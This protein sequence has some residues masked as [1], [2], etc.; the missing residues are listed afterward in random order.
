MINIFKDLAAFFVPINLIIK[1]YN[2]IILYHSVG[3]N[4]NFK[5]NIDH[6][7]LEVLKTQLKT[8]QKFWKFIPIDEYVEIK[9][10]KGLASLTVDDGYK[11][12]I[13]E[14]LVVFDYLKIP[15]TIF[16]NSSTFKGKIFWRDKVRFL[17]E[18]NKV[19]EFIN[20]SNLFETKHLK[21][22]YSISKNPVYSSIEVENEIDKFIQK[23]DLKINDRYKFCFDNEKYLIKHPLVSYGNHTANHYVLSSLTREEQYNEIIECKN[24]LKE[25]DINISKVFSIPFG[26][27][28]SFNT[29]TLKNIDDL[30]YKAILKSTNDLDNIFSFNEIN[31]FMPKT[32]KIE[33]TLKK[34]YLKKILKR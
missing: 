3:S 2:P 6:V 27:N 28:N 24:F 30:N 1:S 5:D 13:D 4:P 31:R 11:N 12:V 16:I 34:M 14:A 15:I 17:I 22:F 26:G 7:S 18:N 32:Y 19:D 25:K 10:K 23:E 29:D 33:N 8:I 21:N 9:N 20:S